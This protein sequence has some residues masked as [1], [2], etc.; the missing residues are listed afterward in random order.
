MHNAAMSFQDQP[1]ELP[2][3]EQEPDI[4]DLATSLQ[5]AAEGSPSGRRTPAAGGPWQ[6]QGDQQAALDCAHA[7]TAAEVST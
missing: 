4:V 2:H 1:A 6:F 3:A 5:T 7:H